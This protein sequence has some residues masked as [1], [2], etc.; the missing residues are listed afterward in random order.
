MPVQVVQNKVPADAG[1]AP[2]VQNLQTSSSDDADIGSFDQ[3]ARAA[4][5]EGSLPPDAVRAPATAKQQT[6]IKD[7][8]E[9]TPRNAPCPCGSGKKFKMCHGAS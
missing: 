6:V 9:K 3:A 1:D 4:V 5:A 8:F 7:Q 2:E